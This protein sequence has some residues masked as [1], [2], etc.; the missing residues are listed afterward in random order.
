MNLLLLLYKAGVFFMIPLKSRST[1]QYSIVRASKLLSMYNIMLHLWRLP[2]II[3]TKTL[4]EQCSS[5]EAGSGP[6]HVKTIFTSGNHMK[7]NSNSKLQWM[8]QLQYDIMGTQ[9]IREKIHTFRREG[10]GHSF[11]MWNFM[12]LI[13]TNHFL[14]KDQST[15]LY[16]LPLNKL[17]NIS[18]TV[19]V[20]IHIINVWTVQTKKV[21]L[22]TEI[23]RPLPCF[24]TPH[25]VLTVH[26]LANHLPEQCV[27]TA[28]LL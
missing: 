15:I 19:C 16:L 22:K 18:L 8:K 24:P 20:L 7:V 28:V 17:L 2:F 9:K 6:K 14:H 27:K 4:S 25:N 12:L 11:S 13:K 1:V 23:L 3:C 21:L 5:S 10:L 26:T